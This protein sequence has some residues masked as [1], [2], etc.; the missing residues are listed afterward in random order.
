MVSR[1]K[2]KARNTLGKLGFFGP[3]AHAHMHMRTHAH[4]DTHIQKLT[5]RKEEVLKVE[6]LPLVSDIIN[7]V[8]TRNLPN[9]KRLSLQGSQIARR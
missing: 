5:F 9:L 6:W 2:Q 3:S 1:H 7:H 8:D 4:T